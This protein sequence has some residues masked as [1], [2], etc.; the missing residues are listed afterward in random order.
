MKSTMKV[1]CAA[2]LLSMVSAGCYTQL[3]TREGAG[4]AVEDEETY[5]SSD[6]ST[7]AVNNAYFGDD[8]YR[9]HRFNL[10]FNYYHPGR[11]AYYDGVYDPWFDDPWFWPM[12]WRPYVLYPYPTW[13]PYGSMYGNDHYWGYHNQGWSNGA[14][15][16]GGRGMPSRPRSIGTTRGDDP[17]GLR[18]RT[19]FVTPSASAGGATAPGSGIRTRGTVD[20]PRQPSAAEPGR[21]TT[22]SGTRTRGNDVPWW[23]RTK[24]QDTKAGQ[25]QNVTTQ[26]PAQQPAASSG[27]Q[28][29]VQQAPNT[30]PNNRPNSTP[31]ASDRSK[32]TRND[33][34]QTRSQPQ[35]V[36]PPQSQPRSAPPAS[37]G[38]R[39]RSGGSSSGGSSSNSGSSSGSGTRQR[40]R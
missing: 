17:R 19:P 20:E 32:R 11:W 9:Y 23:E 14:M 1:I 38:G 28:R 34:G 10:S 16:G 12:G 26:A 6:T 4:G 7:T 35:Q 24:Q 18:T 27:R 30:N 2:F 29:R 37:S 39:E 8:D 36:S 13:Y 5:A 40:E 3:A 31:G 21:S 22:T 15:A 33:G 25:N